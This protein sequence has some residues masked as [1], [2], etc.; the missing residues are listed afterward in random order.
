MDTTGFSLKRLVTVPRE[1]PSRFVPKEGEQSPIWSLPVPPVVV[2]INTPSLQKKI[3]LQYINVSN[4]HV[5]HLEF[6][7][8]CMLIISQCFLRKKYPT[9]I[10]KFI[11]TPFLQKMEPNS[12]EGK[13]GFSDSSKEHTMA[14][15]T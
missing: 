6:I 11:N 10:N 7:Q 12:L 5:V 1:P 4:Q 3:I 9:K 13:A 15:V 8:C 2:F 14:E